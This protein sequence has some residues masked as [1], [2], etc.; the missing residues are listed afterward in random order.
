MTLLGHKHIRKAEEA[1]FKPNF[2]FFTSFSTAEA[3]V[4]VVKFIGFY[5]TVGFIAIR[6]FSFWGDCDLWSDVWPAI[7]VVVCLLLLLEEE[8]TIS[9]NFTKRRQNGFK[10]ATRLK[11]A[12]AK[13]AKYATRLK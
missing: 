2:T 10:I 4:C 8:T 12:N 6:N 3:H 1:N 11:Y 13:Y 7:D 9:N 5:G